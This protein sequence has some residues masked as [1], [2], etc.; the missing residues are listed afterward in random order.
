MT[1]GDYA[2]QMQTDNFL[3]MLNASCLPTGPILN[4]LSFPQ[5]LKGVV[6]MGSEVEV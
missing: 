5:L 1:D 3:Q 2:T 4:A 6:G